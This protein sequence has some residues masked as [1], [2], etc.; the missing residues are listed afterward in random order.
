MMDD[1]SRKAERPYHR[2][3]EVLKQDI[4]QFSELAVQSVTDAVDSLKNID[5]RLADK[6]IRN[7]DLIDKTDVEI[8][9]KAMELIALHQPMAIDLR[10]LGTS[11]KIITYLDRIGRYARDIAEVTLKIADQGH[12]KKVVT[13]P[14]MRD[15]AV[16]MVADAVKAY[17][18]EDSEVAE[19]VYDR[20]DSVDA[21]Y[22]EIFRECLTYMMED[23]K[24]ITQSIHYIL[25]ARYLERIAD[26]SC[27]IAEKAIYIATGRRRREYAEETGA[28]APRD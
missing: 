13:I 4:V 18:N 10:V 6:V 16:G 12:Y 15:I 1:S 25:V 7:D 21:L 20:D 9:R 28:E 11:L 17:M 24:K 19:S 23:S 8:E 2:Q 22:D 14:H 3:V 27:K 26:N 5:R